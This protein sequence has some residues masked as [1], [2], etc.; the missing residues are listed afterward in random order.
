[1]NR[2]VERRRYGVAGTVPGELQV[3]R[4]VHPARGRVRC[5][6]SPLVAAG[7]RRAGH[8]V[9][10]PAHPLVPHGESGPGVLFTASFLDHTGTPVGLAVAAHEADPAGVAAASE[11]V[12]LWS[13]LWRTR[14]VMVADLPPACCGGPSDGGC[15]APSAARKAVR[16]YA[17]EGD[18]VVI[19]GRRACASASALLAQ[20]PG[21]AVVVEPGC[22]VAA[23][24]LPADRVRYLIQPGMP[25]EEAMTVVASLRARYPALRG[26]RLEDLCYAAS[27]RLAVARA[28]A[29]S[30]DR[31]FLLGTPGPGLLR[32]V[33]GARVHVV[34]DPAVLRPSWLADAEC[35]G[36]VPGSAASGVPVRRWIDVLSG[37]G[38]VSVVRRSVHTRTERTEPTRDPVPSGFPAPEIVC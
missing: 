23:L 12:A 14:R 20:A 36:I 17:D 18:H 33:S 13:A 8:R 21:R 37:L 28:M 9:R 19:V 30:C 29:F 32:A 35:V 27:D 15:P 31:L 16:S 3:A 38:P 5:P 10:E 2:S 24:R 1:M 26:P 7:L 25:V 11:A 6:A 34:A 22:D 4:F